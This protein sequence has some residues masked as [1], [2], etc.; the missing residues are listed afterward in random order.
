MGGGRDGGRGSEKM[1]EVRFSVA[2][3]REQRGW[4]FF[5]APH[6]SPDPDLGAQNV[7]LEPFQGEVSCCL[8]PTL[9]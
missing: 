1:E 9:T 4:F 2:A 6:S 3:H 5:R 8:G 7:G